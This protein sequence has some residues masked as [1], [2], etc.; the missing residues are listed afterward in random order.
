VTTTDLRRAGRLVSA[1]AIVLVLLATT[2]SA[3]AVTSPLLAAELHPVR[4]PH[5]PAVVETRAAPS[6][7]VRRLD[8]ISERAHVS[9]SVLDEKSGATFD[10]GSGRFKTA[11]LFKLHLVALMSW[12]AAK[13]GERLTA[14]QR[15]DVEQ[16]LVR[17]D[18]DAAL[19]TYYGLGGRDGIEHALTSAYGAPGVRVGDLGYW[20]HSSTTPRDIVELL[21][22]VLDPDAE[23]TYAL[24][25]DAMARVVPEQRWGISVLADR[26][27]MVQTKVGWF[28]DPDGWIVNSSGRVVVDGS[29]VL[30][31]V[32]TDRNP[33]LEFGIATIEEVARLAGDVVRERRQGTRRSWLDLGARIAS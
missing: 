22:R 31:S 9:V 12:R 14:G 28:E 1:L 5:E 23:P 2:E 16:M 17:S 25:Q 11:S 4:L 6:R 18:N 21:D 10:H 32:M 7:A 30:I 24:M 26:G 27:T 13:S 20:G 29:P 8:Q 15:R 33:T 19:R 3:P